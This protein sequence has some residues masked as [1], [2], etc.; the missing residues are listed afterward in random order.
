M[1]GDDTAIVFP[2]PSHGNMESA[3]QPWPYQVRPHWQPVFRERKREIRWKQRSELRGG[4]GNH[5]TGLQTGDS[6]HCDSGVRRKL[7]ANPLQRKIRQG[8]H[9]RQSEQCLRGLHRRLVHG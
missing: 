4:A 3:V 1:G 5:T 8:D 2:N 9:A 7:H 6:K